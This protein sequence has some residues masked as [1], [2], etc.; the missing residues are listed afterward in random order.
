LFLCAFGIRALEHL[1]DVEESAKAGAKGL[2]RTPVPASA[3]RSVMF[4]GQFNNAELFAKVK[5]KALP[6]M[7]R[8]F[9]WGFF[10]FF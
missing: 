5:G 1:L 10:F 9:F 6:G 8:E 2:W 3:V 7:S 4:N